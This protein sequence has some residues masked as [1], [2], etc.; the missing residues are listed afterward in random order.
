MFPFFRLWFGLLARCFRSHPPG[1]FFNPGAENVVTTNTGKAFIEPRT[2]QSAGCGG[3][4][5][6]LDLTSLQVT[7][8]GSIGAIC[9][10]P[11][12]FPIAA[13]TD[14]S[15]VLLTTSDISGPQQIA[16][17]D[18]ATN[19]WAVNTAVASNFGAVAG[20]SANG[21]VFASGSAIVDANAN[22][23]GYLVF[24]EVTESGVG[25]AVPMEKVSDGAS[26]LRPNRLTM[27]V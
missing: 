3:N 25:F 1:T 2:L 4:F 7:T 12:G 22:L 8:I 19:S 21:S 10:Q 17:Y 18:A 6:E 16:I 24:Q 5:Y 26:S 13:S 14:G 15:K 11:E 9:I 27:Q 23:A 20:V